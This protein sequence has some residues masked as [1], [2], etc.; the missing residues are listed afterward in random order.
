MSFDLYLL[1]F[2]KGRPCDL[3]REAVRSTLQSCDCKQVNESFYD[4]TL[5]D[6]SHIELQAGGLSGSAP[7]DTCIFRI[8]GLNLAKAGLVLEITKA[9]GGVLIPPS[10]NP[11][12]LGDASQLAELP[13][14]FAP[15]GTRIVECHS[16]E[17]LGRM[18]AGDYQSWSAYRDQVVHGNERQNPEG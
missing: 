8:R 13:A 2:S 18:L 10:C 6:G 17:D 5:A 12:I 9:A 3:P 14:N 1:K 15:P 4:I 7:F 16:A 11:R